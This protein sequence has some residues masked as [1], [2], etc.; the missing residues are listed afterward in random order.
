MIRGWLAPSPPE[1]GWGSP[2]PTLWGGGVV[3][4]AHMGPIWDQYGAQGF[5]SLRNLFHSATPE[6]SRDESNLS[7]QTGCT[8]VPSVL[9]RLVNFVCSVTGL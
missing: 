1:K 3:C 7:Q 2:A 5:R 9:Q 8:V 4:G 6:K